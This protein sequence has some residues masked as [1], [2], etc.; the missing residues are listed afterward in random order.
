[1]FLSFWHMTLYVFQICI[2]E[3]AGEYIH[4]AFHCWFDL[5]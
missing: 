4:G 1:M 2:I 5:Y 3:L